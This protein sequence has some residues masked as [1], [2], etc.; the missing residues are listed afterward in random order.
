MLSRFRRMVPVI[1]FVALFSVVSCGDDLEPIEGGVIF[2]IIETHPGP[3]CEPVVTLLMR[4]EKIYS[5]C[6]IEIAADVSVDRNIILV[7]LAGIRIPDVFLH[8]LG[9]ATASVLLRPGYCVGAPA[10]RSRRA[11]IALFVFWNLGHVYL[12]SQRFIY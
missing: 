5:C 10:A 12:R 7:T 11:H 2:K 4:T 9:P 1:T 3:P 8:M 6:N